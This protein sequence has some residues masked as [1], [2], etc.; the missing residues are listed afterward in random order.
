LCDLKSLEI[1]LIPFGYEPLLRIM[2]NAMLKKAAAKSR[3]EAAKLR[4][5][6]KPGLRPPPIPEKVTFI[7][8]IAF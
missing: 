5:K 6:F 8:N 7:P 3:N 1:K 4:K 2:E